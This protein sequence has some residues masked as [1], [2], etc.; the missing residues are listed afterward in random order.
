MITLRAALYWAPEPADPLTQ[1]GNAW[2]GW[3]PERGTQV[4]QPPINGLADATAAPRLYGFH[5]TLRPPMRLATGWEEFI[6]AAHAIAASAAPFDLPPLRVV[7]TDGFL[8]LAEA[9]ASPALHSLAEACVRGTDTHRLQPD[10]AELA[11]RRA[12]GL[13]PRQDEMLLRWGYPDVMQEWRF[14][15][16]LSGRL[17]SAEMRRLRPAAETHFAAALAVTR[18]VESITVFTQRE[19]QAFLIA[20]RIQLASR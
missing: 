4:P 19:G 2:L 3:D 13:S 14:H 7:E 10:T 20:E 5:A 1:A 8:A 9:V 15:M 12:A 17:D 6:A 18:R 16:T 11:R